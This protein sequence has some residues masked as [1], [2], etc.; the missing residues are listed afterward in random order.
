MIYNSK[1][2]KN[3]I[4]VLSAMHGRQKTVSKCLELLPESLDVFMVYST[5]E[6]GNF[7]SGKV[8]YSSQHSNEI[9]SRKW[10]HGIYQLRNIDFDA[11][12]ILGSDDYVDDAFIDYID[13]RI[14]EYDF[15]GFLDMYYSKEN[16]LYYWQ[17]Y[18]NHRKGEPIGAGRVYTKSMLDRMNYILY[19]GS[20]Q[21]GLDALAWRVLSTYECKKHISRLKENGLMC[22]D[23]KD[24][25][26]ITPL[27]KLKLERV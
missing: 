26:G 7:L 5:K 25:K 4:I 2:M 6:D 18:T 16:N 10:Q 8:K 27:N 9:L 20:R 14:S 17:G 12:I 1:N 24:E 21:S 22:C 13:S 15:I 11:V 3:K 19:D 23:V